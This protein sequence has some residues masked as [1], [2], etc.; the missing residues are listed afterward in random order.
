[1][2]KGGLRA[3]FYLFLNHGDWGPDPQEALRQRAPMTDMTRLFADGGA[4]PDRY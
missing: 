1:M 2:R 4:I 3:A